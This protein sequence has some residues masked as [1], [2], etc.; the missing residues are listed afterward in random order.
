MRAHPARERALGRTPDHRPFRERVGERECRARRCR[1][2]LR[3]RRARAPASPARQPGRWR[4]SCPSRDAERGDDV[5]PA[6]DGARLLA[7]LR[8]EPVDQLRAAPAPPGAGR[9]AARRPRPPTTSPCRDEHRLE[10]APA[11]QL[12]R[13]VAVVRSSSGRKPVRDDLYLFCR[14]RRAGAR[15]SE[16]RRCSGRSAPTSDM[17]LTRTWP[18]GRGDADELG[19]RVVGRGRGR[20]SSGPPKQTVTSKLSSA[21]RERS[22]TSPTCASTSGSAPAQL[23]EL[24]RRDVERDDVGAEPHELER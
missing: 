3:R 18:P 17:T 12:H 7:E 24:A 11:V 23:V 14:R 10:L 8:L 9:G 2:L 16:D 1:R 19:E 20:S 13:E 5:L 15:S 22:V 21:K 4:A 6:R